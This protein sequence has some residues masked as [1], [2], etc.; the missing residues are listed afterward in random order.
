MTTGPEP[1]ARPGRT[2]PV[3]EPPAPARLSLTGVGGG[4]RRIDGVWWP[5]THDVCKE[6]TALLLSLEAEG[7]PDAV[8]V[9]L[10][11]VAWPAVPRQIRVADRIVHVHW[12]ATGH[13]R[14]QICLVLQGVGRWDL[15]V[16]PPETPHDQA[17]HLLAAGGR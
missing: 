16:V 17:Q 13:G 12:F 9:T 3:P 15:L 8:R 2:R 6:L 5:R 7:E 1:S 4:P 11:A 10:D 14:H